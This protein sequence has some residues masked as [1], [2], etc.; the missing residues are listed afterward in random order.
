MLSLKIINLE[1]NIAQST[2]L[3]PNN[4]T[5]ACLVGRN[6]SCDIVLDDPLVSNVHGI[7]LKTANKWSYLDLLST[8]S[9]YL[10]N[11]EVQENE[12]QSLKIRDSI[13]I[14]DSWL[15]VEDIQ[16]N[17][18]SGE[19]DTS[20]GITH[21]WTQDQLTVCCV[22]AIEKTHDV[23]TF[24]FAANPPVLFD[25]KPGQFVTL[26]L[27]INGRA[28][29]RSYTVSSTPS[30]PHTL[31]ITVKRVP[32]PT[33]TLNAPAGL[34]SNWL[35]D[36]LQ[37]GSEIEISPPMGD[38]TC[39]GHSARKILFVSA[40]SGITPMMSMAR[41]AYDA[42]PDLDIAFFHSARSS[43]DVIFHK[44]LEW[45]SSQHHNFHLHLSLTREDKQSDWSGLTGRLDAQMLAQIAPDFLERD[46][47]VCGSDGFM[48]GVKTLLQ[49]LDFPMDNYYYESFGACELPDQTLLD[50]G[51]ANDTQI[52][53]ATSSLVV[54][55]K[56]GTEIQCQP[57]ESI[58]QVGK[59]ENIRLNSACKMGRCG[60]C[61]IK[62]ITGEVKY[63]G[64]ADR[65]SAD[66]QASG[67]ILA[68]IA[69][70]IGRVEVEA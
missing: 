30:R 46:V 53:T 67:L 69:Y 10:N 11:I 13:Y 20:M 25:Y 24:R 31:E 29:E 60:V 5:G 59:R 17:G 21:Q 57:E 27:N 19:G 55:S 64:P 65:L 18:T 62:K 68:C 47:Y 23:K 36:N 58:L 44:E 35:H 37:V 56:S 49:G 42:A 7:F 3:T 28:V 63:K 52:G 48:Q 34:V 43:R 39:V 38:F 22:G 6:P 33:H 40:G 41:W 2:V 1:T 8:N 66:E 9:S 45:M 61:K 50:A 15:L 51:V 4:P 54:F 26:T 16:Q 32:A 14:G 70:P 12:S